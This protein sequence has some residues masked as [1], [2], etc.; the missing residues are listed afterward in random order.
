LTVEG[1]YSSRSPFCFLRIE[2]R[3]SGAE[4]G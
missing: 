4:R 2:R 3:G 1:N